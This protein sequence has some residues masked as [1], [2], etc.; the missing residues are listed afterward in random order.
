LELVG[1]AKRET[2]EHELIARDEALDT[3][4][5]RGLRPSRRHWPAFE[6]NRFERLLHMQRARLSIRIDSVPIK[7]SVG[8]VACLLDLGDE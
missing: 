1:R 7:E 5:A 8:G 4:I 6:I 2:V 3:R